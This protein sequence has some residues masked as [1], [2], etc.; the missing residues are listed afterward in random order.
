MTWV[1]CSG[2][3]AHQTFLEMVTQFELAISIGAFFPVD[4]AVQICSVARF[5]FNSM[6]NFISVHEKLRTS[7]SF[8]IAWCV[9]RI[10]SKIS[11]AKGQAWLLR[12]WHCHMT[13][14]QSLELFFKVN[15]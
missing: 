7:F 14:I 5:T 4:E 6:L 10:S 15:F 3:R 12:K 1:C 13:F 2:Y 9:L 11:I 8:Q